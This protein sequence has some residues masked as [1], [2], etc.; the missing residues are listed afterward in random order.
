I[1]SSRSTSTRSDATSAA[2]QQAHAY[3]VYQL[4]SIRTKR[5]LLLID[6]TQSKLASRE[7][8]IRAK[9]ADFVS[10]TGAKDPKVAETKI[11]KQRARVYP[12][13][14]KVYD[15]IVLNLEQMRDLEAV[16]QDGDLAATVEARIAF[17]KASRALYI[18]RSYALV[19]QFPSALSLNSRGKL[20]A[21]EA[22]SLADSLDTDDYEDVDFVGDL[23][24]LSASEFDQLDKDLAADSERAGHDWYAATGGKVDVEPEDL[25]V[26]GMD[27]EGGKKVKKEAFY[28]IAYSYVAAF[29]IDA[30]ARKAGLA[31]ELAPVVQEDVKMAV[32]EE[33]EVEQQS[34]PKKGWGFGLFGRR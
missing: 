18:S 25:E 19:D 20:Y 24:A 22:R 5:D 17:V 13:L 1:A 14:V 26:E 12:G 3:I 6:D 23:L 27:L 10:E 16:E 9:E 30:I 33:V 32:E 34:T 8:K 11:K 31:P 2:L 4:L 29:D 15:G 28:D 21:R 7:T